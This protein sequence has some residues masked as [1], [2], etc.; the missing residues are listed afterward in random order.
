MYIVEENSLILLKKSLYNYNIYRYFIGLLE[1]DI[2][3]SK[4]KSRTYLRRPSR[5]KIIL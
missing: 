4:M 5:T 1:M 2:S 3:Y